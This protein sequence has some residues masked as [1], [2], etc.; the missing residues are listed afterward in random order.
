MAETGKG[1]REPFN[2]QASLRDN[3]AMLLLVVDL[4][5]TPRASGTG[6]SMLYGSTGFPVRI[7]HPTIPG[8]WYSVTVG[9]EAPEYAE[10]KAAVAEAKARL[11]AFK[12]AAK[13]E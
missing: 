1:R 11:K 8:L 5:E 9:N 6:K 12:S 7:E 3:D 10:A 2:V 4:N 13:S